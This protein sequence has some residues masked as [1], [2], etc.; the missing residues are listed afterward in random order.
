M[1]QRRP[2]GTYG[3]FGTKSTLMYISIHIHD[4]TPVQIYLFYLGGNDI[5]FVHGNSRV[6]SLVI[7][8]QIYLFYLGGNLMVG[9]TTKDMKGN[10]CCFH[11]P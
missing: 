11:A 7:F 9:A 6:D 5:T 1:N 10:I 8:L 3:F 4:D 2:H